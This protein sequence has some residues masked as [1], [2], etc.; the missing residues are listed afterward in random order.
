VVKEFHDAG[1]AI[2]VPAESVDLAD[3]PI[4]GRFGEIGIKLVLSINGVNEKVV[5]LEDSGSEV[6]LFPNL[7]TEFLRKRGLSGTGDAANEVDGGIS[8]HS[9]GFL[10]LYSIPTRPENVNENV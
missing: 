9:W 2:P 6:A 3:V 10:S 8:Y 5:R 1:G 7:V 4:V